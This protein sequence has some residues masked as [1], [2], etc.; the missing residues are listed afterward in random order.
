MKDILL[1]VLVALIV[2]LAVTGCVFGCKKEG[3]LSQFGDEI[4]DPFIVDYANFPATYDPAQLRWDA[5]KKAVPL[6][7]STHQYPY[8]ALSGDIY[9][10]KSD[11]GYYDPP[12]A[13]GY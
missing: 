1:V 13:C 11:N 6:E 8:T 3:F 9:R 2:L 12:S 10:P 7:E 4:H 5:T